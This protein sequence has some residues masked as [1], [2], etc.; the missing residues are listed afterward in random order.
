MP[1]GGLWLGVRLATKKQKPFCRRKMDD[2]RVREGKCWRLR[3]DNK[4]CVTHDKRRNNKPT[5]G[6]VQRSPRIL[7]REAGPLQ[8]DVVER[9]SAS[10]RGRRASYEL[11]RTIRI[12][13]A[14]S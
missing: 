14:E 5:D 13:K 7:I 9:E 4:N 11:L 8:S 12:S 1:E 2:K 10:R 3:Q 6:L